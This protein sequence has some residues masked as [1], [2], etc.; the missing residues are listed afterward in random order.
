MGRFFG[1]YNEGSGMESATSSAEITRLLQAWGGG[2]A[3]ALESLTPLVYTELRRM[4]RR[5]MR[6]EDPGHTLQP[7]AL[8]NEAYLRLVD[9]AQVRWQDRAHLFAVAAHT[10]RRVLVDSARARTAG[11]RGGGAVHVNLDESI[12]GMPDRTA[13][14]WRWT[15]PWKRS[16]GSIRARRK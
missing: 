1:A 12:D 13:S 11:K 14:W 9:I 5:S 15:M 3:A 7:T 6:G 8:V 16:P 4:A 10:M 2:D